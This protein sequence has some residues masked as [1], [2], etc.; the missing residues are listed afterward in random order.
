VLTGLPD[1]ASLG[2]QELLEISSGH[3]GGQIQ[4]MGLESGAQ[5]V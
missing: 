1:V 4:R 3:F 2:A 5:A